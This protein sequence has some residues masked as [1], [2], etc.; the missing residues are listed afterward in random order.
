MGAWRK[1]IVAHSRRFLK[2]SK[3][4]FCLFHLHIA[5]HLLRTGS[6]YFT[7][8]EHPIILNQLLPPKSTRRATRASWYVG[9]KIL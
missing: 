2:L 4:A 9:G 5:E 6:W 8:N 3:A 7:I 1:E